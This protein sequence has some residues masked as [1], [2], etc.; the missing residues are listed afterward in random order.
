MIS[1]RGGSKL[2][3]DEGKDVGGRRGNVFLEERNRG[4]AKI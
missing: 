3:N 4:S 1:R 2:E